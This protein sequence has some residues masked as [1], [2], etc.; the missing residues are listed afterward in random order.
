M[1]TQITIGFV[2]STRVSNKAKKHVSLG[3]KVRKTL[4]III[5]CDSENI[6]IAESKQIRLF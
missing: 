5:Q 6:A 4:A 1:F 3:Y 2:E